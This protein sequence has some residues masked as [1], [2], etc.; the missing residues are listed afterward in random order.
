LNKTKNT[1]R[2]EVQE[3]KKNKDT[4]S[5]LEHQR[6]K[7]EKTEEA[8]RQTKHTKRKVGGFHTKQDF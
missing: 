1:S 6:E 8:S 3:K 5:E 4:F 2:G 7:I